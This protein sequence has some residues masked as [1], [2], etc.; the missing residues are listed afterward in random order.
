MS[1]VAIG[2]NHK[3]AS[4]DLLERLSVHGD[5]RL[6]TFDDLIGR[7]NIS[8][9]VVLSTCNRTEVY[10]VAERFHGAY[11]DIRAH[12]S[13]RSSLDPEQFVDDLYVHY[14]DDAIRHLF[15]VASGLD[16]AVLGESEILGQV[17][18]AWEAARVA[19][20]SGP[21]L[22]LVFRHA[23]TT[24]KR[25]RTETAIG[26]NTTSV[27]Q[28]AVSMADERLDGLRGR[29]VMVIGAGEMAD[30]MLKSLADRGLD[31]LLVA[32]R[33]PERAVELAERI[34]G[35]AVA[36]EKLAAEL[37]RID[38]LLT[39]TGASSIIVDHADLAV[40]L[41]GRESRPLVIVD[42]AV[43]R[44]VDPSAAD[45][46]GVTLLD[47]DDLTEFAARGRRERDREVAAVDLII[48]SEVS[49]F[50]ELRSA[51]GVAPLIASLHR[52]A[53]AIRQLEVERSDRL[54]SDLT[55][56]EREAVETMSR[57]L[58]AKLLHQPTVALNDAAG[59]PKG[60]RLADSLRDL[61]DL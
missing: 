23:I 8:E 41:A 47:M 10:V 36:L 17:K 21:V 43:P 20:V 12:F 42:I 5:D 24:G 33:T 34:G 16:S 57:R 54:L 56:A 49:R 45:L 4:L 60:D 39:G 7:D 2:L 6:K 44:D 59:S 27:S 26:R 25:A 40:A 61:F 31:E 18:D 51:C 38:L 13:D 9:T 19:D 3:S 58:I 29:R 14:D 50:A 53:E 52:E 55:P 46:P 35:T 11:E 30:G 28:A 22:N 32:N 15:R 1:I 37:G 48:D